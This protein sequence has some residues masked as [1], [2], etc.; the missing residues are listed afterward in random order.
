MASNEGFAAINDGKA[1]FDDIYNQPDPAPYY[2][3]LGKLEYGIP[4]EAKPV[5]QRVIDARRTV[6]DDAVTVLDIGCSYGINAA[7]LKH[8]LE[9]GQLY[10]WY[11]ERPAASPAEA[12]AADRA[13]FAKQ[14]HHEDLTMIG[15][16]P[17]ERAIGYAVETGLLNAGV[18]AD[19][20]SGP[21]PSRD[22][23]VLRDVDVIT[24]TGAIG[25]VTEK[26]FQQ[27][28]PA[29]DA[30]RQPWIAC[31]VLRM[32]PY[33][34]IAHSFNELG[35]VTEKLE[36]VYFPQRRFADEQEAAHVLGQLEALD[37][38]AGPESADGQYV[39]EFY[40]SR[41]FHVVQQRPLTSLLG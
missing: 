34:P 14:P 7:L 35:L 12:V 24:A 25:Y 37:I 8:D 18:V 22:L 26:T 3:K 21:L 32:F 20:E 23:P 6:Q 39:A 13:F 30:A 11:E 40:L 1:D 17:A 41:P 2:R 31:F 15:M 33:E 28:L 9:M 27:L 38:D 16:D 10:D 29:I 19:L 4:G 36:G 5:L